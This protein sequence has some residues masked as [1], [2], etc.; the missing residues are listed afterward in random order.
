MS[1]GGLYKQSRVPG[2]QEALWNTLQQPQCRQGRC[3][4]YWAHG[5]VSA[6]QSLLHS[7]AL[8][9]AVG[10]PGAPCPQPKAMRPGSLVPSIG[11]VLGGQSLHCSLWAMIHLI[12]PD[13]GIYV[14]L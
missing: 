11:T 14:T 8:R 6:D 4:D 3:V 9:A 13:K 12:L 5:C 1:E 2:S 10:R 7:V